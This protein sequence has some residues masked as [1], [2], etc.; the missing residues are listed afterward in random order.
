MKGIKEGWRSFFQE[1]RAHDVNYGYIEDDHT[2]FLHKGVSVLHIIPQP[3]PK[4]WHTL[5]VSVILGKFTVLVL[6]IIFSRMMQVH[7]TY[8]R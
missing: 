5:A 7:W 2:P 4:V 6:M 8:P 3:F 1:R